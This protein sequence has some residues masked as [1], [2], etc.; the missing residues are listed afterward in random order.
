[1]G[2]SLGFE[3]KPA[4]WD[5]ASG[6]LIKQAATRNGSACRLDRLKNQAGGMQGETPQ[7][8]AK[9]K[10]NENTDPFK[11]RGLVWQALSRRPGPPP[12]M[13]IRNR[14]DGQGIL[15]SP[16]KPKQLGLALDWLTQTTRVEP[17]LNRYCLNSVWLSS[18]RG[19]G[20]VA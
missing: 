2:V 7:S 16:S 3:L 18:R 19:Q 15:V 12:F 8:P 6:P 20:L 10:A 9:S 1:M 4:Y 17:C 11:G 13:D 14:P 5:A